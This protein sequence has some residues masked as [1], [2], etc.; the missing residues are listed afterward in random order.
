MFERFHG[1]SE[2]INLLNDWLDTMLI[3][4]RVHTVK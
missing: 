3:K 2:A 1:V 4:E